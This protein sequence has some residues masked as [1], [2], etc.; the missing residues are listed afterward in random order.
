MKMD[1]C[2]FCGYAHG[3]GWMADNEYGEVK[4]EFGG[5]F[6]IGKVSQED[7]AYINQARYALI[8]PNPDCQRVNLMDWLGN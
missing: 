8:C 3:W 1:V 2:K 5:F 7:S 6:V 4:G